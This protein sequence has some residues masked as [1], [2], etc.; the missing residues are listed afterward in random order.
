[1][2]TFGIE[3]V[4]REDIDLVKGRSYALI[5]HS[6]SV[7]R[8][9]RYVFER[10]CAAASTRPR[11]IWVPEHGLFGEQAYMEPVP[12]SVDT[13]LSVPIRSLYGDGPDSLAPS[14]EALNGV[15]MVLFDLQD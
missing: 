3:R 8:E 12:D 11:A 7:D 14:R 1:M 6:A 9:G 10:L 2:V 13:R 15:D 5:C 4:F